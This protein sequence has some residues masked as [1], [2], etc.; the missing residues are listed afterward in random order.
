[1]WASMQNVSEYA[2]DVLM[3]SSNSEGCILNKHF[4]KSSIGSEAFLQCLSKKSQKSQ[5]RR[6]LD[7]GTKRPHFYISF[8][9]VLASKNNYCMYT[10]N[11]VNNVTHTSMSMPPH[12]SYKF[13]S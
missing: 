13:L 6:T 11:I 2:T 1:M 5:Y 4:E 9:L 7:R 10:K 8:T 12:T 3:E